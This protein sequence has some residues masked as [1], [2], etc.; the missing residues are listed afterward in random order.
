MKVLVLKN[1]NEDGTTYN[2]YKWPESG[3]VVAP[4]WDGKPSCIGGGFFGWKWGAGSFLGESRPAFMVLEVDDANLIE[5]DGKCKFSECVVLYMGGQIGA[6]NLLKAH[7]DYPKDNILNFD[8]TDKQFVAS[9]HWST[10]T[11]GHGSTQTAGYWSTQTAGYGST[12]KAGDGSTQTAGHESTQK[13]G[14]GSTQK[15][16]DRSTQT[17]G[18][19][20]VQIGYWFDDEGNYQVATRKVT[21]SMANK[22]YRFIKGKWTLIKKGGVG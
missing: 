7:P 9:G 13:A 17:A 21:R 6:I 22:P 20:S 14:D 15:A 5:F 12:Q 4:E 2:G 18:I 11:A 19:N 1:C 3:H 8:I 16:G 10:Q